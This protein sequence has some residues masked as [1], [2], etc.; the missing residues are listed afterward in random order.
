MYVDTYEAGC[1]DIFETTLVI[2]WNT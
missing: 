2:Y 1:P